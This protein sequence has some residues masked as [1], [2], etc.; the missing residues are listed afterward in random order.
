MGMVLM[1]IYRSPLYTVAAWAVC[2]V[3]Q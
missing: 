2:D 3:C 1:S